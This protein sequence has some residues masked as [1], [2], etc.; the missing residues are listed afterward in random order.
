MKTYFI[1]DEQGY[2]KAQFK[3]TKKALLKR[4]ADDLNSQVKLVNKDLTDLEAKLKD[5]PV[6]TLQE[7]QAKLG[8]EIQ[9]K[10]NV[11]E[12]KRLKEIKP[13]EYQAFAMELVD[14]KK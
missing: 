14:L 11:K 3:G 1:I 5:A 6:S 12:I 7:K 9:I 10:A 4:I 13:E 2:L 8:L